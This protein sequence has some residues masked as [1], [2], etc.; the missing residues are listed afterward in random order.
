MSRNT[1]KILLIEDNEV[2]ARLI[3]EY[4]LDASRKEDGVSSAVFDLTMKNSLSSGLEFL[5]QEDVD[6]V[7]LDL[8]LPDSVGWETFSKIHKK[9][10]KIPILILTGLSDRELAMKAVREG[11]GDYLVKGEV[12]G[13]LLS[14]SI[15]YAIERKKSEEELLLA[16]N[17]LERK[18]HERTIELKERY[19]E[20]EQLVYAISHDLILPLVTIKG[21][22]GYLK[23]DV[24]S[25]SRQR[26]EIDLGL[27]GDAVERMEALL[28]RALDI[29]SIGKLANA[30][31]KVLFGE[32]VQEALSLAADKI[33]SSGAK[34]IVADDFPMVS[35]DRSRIVDVLVNLIENCIRYAGNIGPLRIEIGY[36]V[37]EGETVFFV[38]DDGP[39]IDPLLQKD[40]FRLF[41]RGSEAE[42]SHA[43]LALSRR[44]IEVH[45]GRMWIES[46][47]NKGCAVYFTIP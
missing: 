44:I 20:I 10:P 22:L 31:T 36:Q 9:K 14:R 40:I 4:L 35:V 47:V 18:I 15:G 5:T 28:V 13:R 24:A 38:K 27:M 11:A 7:L 45:G 46:V 25:G 21:F 17:N 32:I 12:D 34:I 26:I 8:N 6:A 29:S 41:Y 37:K 19:D 43:G 1:L 33:R 2:D 39:G 3:R 42:N 30:R 23:K 16:Q